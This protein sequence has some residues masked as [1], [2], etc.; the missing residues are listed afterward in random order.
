MAV[1]KKTIIKN[2]ALAKVID[3]SLTNLEAATA[4]G[5]KALALATKNSKQSAAEGKRLSKKRIT[6][7]KRRKTAS[8]K[9]QKDPI[10][11][12]KKALSAVDK[13]LAAIRKAAAKNKVV[14]AANFEELSGLRV[15]C[16]RLSAYSKAITAAD[17]V[18]NKPKKKTRRRKAA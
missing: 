5:A 17:K 9:A 1:S 3:N 2:A 12:N 18:L 11:A 7:I 14:R 16:R 13:E 6:L 8:A 10:A 15:S 4:N